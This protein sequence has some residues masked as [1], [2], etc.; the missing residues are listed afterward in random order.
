MSAGCSGS[1]SLA[2]SL[3]AKVMAVER[4]ETP[5]YLKSSVDGMVTAMLD[6]LNW[7]V[8]AASRCPLPVALEGCSDPD[9][10]YLPALATIQYAETCP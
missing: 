5:G 9:K 2:E 3:P 10:D 8:L 4:L 1:D 6:R 7:V